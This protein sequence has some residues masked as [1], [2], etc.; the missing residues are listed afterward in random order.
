MLAGAQVTTL[1]VL[2]A[3][4]FISGTSL[5]NDGTGF[6][7]AAVIGIVSTTGYLAFFVALRLGPV[8]VVGPIVGAYGGIAVLIAIFV[9]GEAVRPGQAVGVISALVGIALTGLVLD[10]GWRRVRF[11]GPGIAFALV[12]SV[13]FAINVTGLSTLVSKEGWL[14]GLILWRFWLTAFSLL[15]FLVA[16]LY[17]ALRG[18]RSAIAVSGAQRISNRDLAVI[19]AAGLTDAGAV[20]SL[21]LGLNFSYVWLVGLISSFGPLSTAL[22]GVVI[23]GERLRRAQIVGLAFVAVSFVFL[24]FG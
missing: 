20:L 4:A 24:S 7:N 15:L 14:Q 23:F 19:A 5:P 17:R 12:A 21:S 3:I 11:F 1:G 6:A 16:A 13:G 18:R 2:L 10:E 9:L 8:A 22:S